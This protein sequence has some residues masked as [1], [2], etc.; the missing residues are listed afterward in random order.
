MPWVSQLILLLGLLAGSHWTQAFAGS[1]AQD[2]YPSIEIPVFRGGYNIQKNMDAAAQTKSVNYV[3]PVNYPAAELIEFY[4]SYFN[5]SG[6]ISSFEICQRHWDEYAGQAIHANPADRQF[7]TSWEH[8]G[9]D[10]KMVLRLIYKRL[11]GQ[12]RDEVAVELRLQ[13]KTDTP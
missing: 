3:A 2:P 6:W 8:S 5:G 9:S 13:K 12:R 10:L 4:D 7:F 11:N 1:P